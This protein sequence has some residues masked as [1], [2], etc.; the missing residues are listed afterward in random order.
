MSYYN[1]QYIL[2]KHSFF[3]IL[4]YRLGHQTEED[5][6]TPT[7]IDA[8]ASGHTI[9]NVACG[10]SKTLALFE[11]DFISISFKSMNISLPASRYPKISDLIE[12]CSSHFSLR[13]HDMIIV[14]DLGCEV[15][16][17]EEVISFF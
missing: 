9:L 16:P 12:K 10:N 1:Q 13:P 2:S 3:L 15:L 14:D 5:K 7:L 6:C 4:G 11:K 17:D 8:L